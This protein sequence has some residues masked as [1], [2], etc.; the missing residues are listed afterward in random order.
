[1][2][3]NPPR[4]HEESTVGPTSHRIEVIDNPS[5]NLQNSNRNSIPQVELVEDQPE[6]PLR[7][8]EILEKYGLG[9]AT[10]N[11]TLQQAQRY[12]QSQV[13]QP[14]AIAYTLRQ[15]EVRETE[16]AMEKIV[17][18]AELQRYDEAAAELLAVAQEKMRG[19]LQYYREMQN[20][21]HELELDPNTTDLAIQIE[22]RRQE[23]G[24]LFHSMR[25]DLLAARGFIDHIPLS[26]KTKKEQLLNEMAR[27]LDSAEFDQIARSPAVVEARQRESQEKIARQPTQPPRPVVVSQPNAEIREQMQ[28]KERLPKRLIKGLGT[29]ID[30]LLP[31]GRGYTGAA[32]YGVGFA[33]GTVLHTMY[34][35]KK[36]MTATLYTSNFVWERYAKW[37]INRA[38]NETQRAERQK[39]YE[40]ARK[41]VLA[42]TAGYSAAS[43]AS[44]VSPERMQ[45]LASGE[46]LQN[47]EETAKKGINSLK[48]RYN[49]SLLKP[50]VDTTVEKGGEVYDSFREGL[51]SGRD[52]QI[53]PTSE[54]LPISEPIEDAVSLNEPAIQPFIEQAV[55]KGTEVVVGVGDTVETLANSHGVT[56]EV[57]YGSREYMAKLFYANHA[58]FSQ[59]NPEAAKVFLQTLLENPDIRI[60]EFRKRFGQAVHL[61]RPG[62]E[63]FVPEP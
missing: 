50:I 53:E 42:L 47:M 58:I 34:P 48:E 19:C 35:V 45:Q 49:Q 54:N 31:F 59:T 43:L 33:T 15:V 25:R 41:T 14:T 61:I 5:Q 18:D 27:M 32:V 22:S 10:V 24:V 6:T 46:L 28:R 52:I 38:K 8:S 55:G 36:V 40:R 9:E 30:P 57:L 26:H 44:L 51:E 2:R 11:N 21:E 4:S 3:R 12:V 13:E 1:M 29:L 63:L 20:L 62:Q 17:R 39:K 60:E 16:N 23:V 7:R 56:D 37:K